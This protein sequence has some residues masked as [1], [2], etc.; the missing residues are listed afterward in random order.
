MDYF[1]WEVGRGTLYPQ[2]KAAAK[3][4]EETPRAR[5]P[6]S[7]G[8]GKTAMNFYVIRHCSRL[9]LDFRRNL[10]QS[11]VGKHIQQSCA[12]KKPPREP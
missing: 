7:P 10:A 11:R 9:R 12:G 2:T 6:K 8:I 1:G 4:Y 5:V 3:A